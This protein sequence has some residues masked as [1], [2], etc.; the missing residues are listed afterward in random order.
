ML[1]RSRGGHI[2]TMLLLIEGLVLMLVVWAVF[3][4]GNGDLDNLDRSFITLTSE[5]N[6]QSSYLQMLAP[7]IVDKTL[8]GIVVGESG[9]F[10]SLFRE[11]FNQ[12]AAEI[13]ALE[14][15]QTNFFAKVRLNEYTFERDTN[16]VYTLTLKDIFANVEIEGHTLTRT[17]DIVVRFTPEGVVGA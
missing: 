3:L 14:K 7:L 13:D 9:D 2:P 17:F 12:R 11:K 16:G 1:G 5:L 10:L 15:R 8:E 6:E 4:G